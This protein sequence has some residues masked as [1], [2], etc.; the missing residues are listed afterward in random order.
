[1]QQVASCKFK[2]LG[3]S[4]NNF[5]T[6][7]GQHEEK[8]KAKKKETREGSFI[9]KHQKEKHGGKEPNMKMEVLKTFRDN[10]TRQITESVYIFRTEQQTEYQLMNS[11]AEWHAPSLYTVRKQI[12]H[13]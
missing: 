2:Y 3:E 8:Y 5:F 6:R 1:M 4:S 11:K 10:L 13:G 12:S 9:Y 7:S